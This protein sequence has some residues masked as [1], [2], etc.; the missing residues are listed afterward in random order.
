MARFRLIV[1]LG[2][3]GRNYVATRHN[4]GF[5]WA[6]KLAR[7]LGA[8]FSHEAKF[9]GEL[10]KAG[11]L[12]LLKPMTY[13]NLS[14]RSVAAAAH[15]FA[16]DAEEILVLHDD[17][18]LAP[19]IVRLKQGGGHA[20]HNGLRDIAT[21]LGSPNFWRLR[22]GIGHPRDSETPQQAVADYVLKP[23]SAEELRLIEGA[24]D[25]AL[26]SWPLL[27]KGDTAEVMRVLHTD[28]NASTQKTNIDKDISS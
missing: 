3:L 2:N 4:A 21:Q 28:G 13:M 26:E 10:A 8:Q 6:D 17:L 20:G 1:G 14:G 5:W 25:R 7:L 22:F 15:F 24:M 12:R 16:I 23:P 11:D 18:D 19:G 9:S 27:G